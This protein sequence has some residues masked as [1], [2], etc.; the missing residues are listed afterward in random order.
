MTDQFRYPVHSFEWHNYLL[1]PWR[2]RWRLR[3]IPTHLGPEFQNFYVLLGKS[4]HW[5]EEEIDRYQWQN[6]SALLAHAARTVPF[7]RRWF[8]E[9]KLAAA[10][11]RNWDDFRNLP[12][13]RRA[14]IDNNL[15]DF[16]S[17]ELKQHRGSP[18]MTSGSSGR[19]LRFF[20]SWD[21][22]S[23]RRAVQWRHF[24]QIG[25]HFK[26]PRVSLNIPFV[27]GEADLLYKYD[28]ID[29]LVMFNGRF[30]HVSSAK[31][32]YDVIQKFKPR[33]FYA[34]PVALATLAKSLKEVGLP[35]LNIPVVYV[36]S[37]VL[38][39]AT[40]R[41]IQ[42]Y[43][44]PNVYDHFGNRENSVNASQFLCGNYHIN[45]EFV[46]TE[47]VPSQFKS[48]GAP[49]GNVVGTNLVNYAMPVIRYDCADLATA[50]STCDKCKIAHKT[51]RFIGGR[52][53]NFLVSKN[54]LL[55]CQYDDF[56]HKLGIE[57]PD[58]IQIEQIDLENLVLHIVA[59]AD[60]VAERDEPLLVS[61]LKDATKGW[62]NIR[63]NYVDVIPMTEGFKKSKVVSRLGVE[64]LEKK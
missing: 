22:E 52:D 11:I 47:L 49:L 19:A 9:Q 51:I 39:A 18:S 58:D 50:I 45:S 10:D 15:A 31:A 63:V 48:E 59:G 43:I 32:I 24:N 5:S 35:P 6:I 26:E 7:Y 44:G 8:S 60:Y 2:L 38:S 14:D 3:T 55:H 21:T 28:P 25:F 12:I 62:F 56:L 37:E 30:I 46:Y 20:R 61:Y 64:Y 40:L 13:I 16:T 54:G 41:T 27:K 36:Y 1:R 33:M 53:K 34:H 29:N 17:S 23:F 42:R 4:L 57:I